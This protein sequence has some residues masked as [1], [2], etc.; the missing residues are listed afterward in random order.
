MNFNQISKKKFLLTGSALLGSVFAFVSVAPAQD[1]MNQTNQGTMGTSPAMQ[2]TAPQRTV[3]SGQRETIN[4]T[5]LRRDVDTFTL[6]DEQGKELT[7]RIGDQT[8]V[9]EREGNPFR[10]GRNYGVT[11]ILRGLDVEVRGRGDS[12]GQLVAERI[13]VRPSDLRTAR[14]I[15]ANVRPVEARVG[16]VEQNAERLSGQLDELAAVANA[17]AGGAKAAQ[18]TADAA[19]GGVNATND[20]ISALDDYVTQETA[21]VNFRTGSAVLS[22]EAKA[23]LDQVATKY[24]SAKN[25]LIEITGYADST[26]NIA[27]NRALSQRR[28]DAVVRYLA[29]QHRIPLRRM[30]TPFGYGEAQPIADDTTREGRAQNRRVEVKVLVNRGL[31]QSA[32]TMTPGAATTSGSSSGMMQN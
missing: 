12:T 15:D 6:L 4:G 26:G 22:T 29:E 14:S 5:I 9:V 10:R 30:V 8:Q 2:S 31:Q 3:A 16:Q 11:S 32:P 13:R 21:A 25:F 24:F 18:E 28:A 19:I 23:S 1:T 20:R 7:V 27:A 17:S